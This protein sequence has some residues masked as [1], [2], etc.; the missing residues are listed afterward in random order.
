M[1]LWWS[2]L[3]S[4]RWG[5]AGELVIS[6]LDN[7][8]TTGRPIPICICSYMVK[9]VDIAYRL[10]GSYRHI[11]CI[12]HKLC[13]ILLV[14]HFQTRLLV[15]ETSSLCT[16]TPVSVLRVMHSLYP[17][18][19]FKSNTPVWYTDYTVYKNKNDTKY[20]IVLSLLQWCAFKHT[21][22]IQLQIITWN[23]V[24]L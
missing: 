4:L 6:N 15:Q 22:M 5:E 9:K 8:T 13:M 20:G 3:L 11:A 2:E 17:I 14:V 24:V 12:I 16:S 10:Y 19:V 21:G 7:T 18:Q 1:N 23:C